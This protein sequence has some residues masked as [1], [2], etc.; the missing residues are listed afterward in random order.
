MVS[1]FCV[2]GTFLTDEEQKT[3]FHSWT[4]IIECRLG[5][6][7]RQRKSFECVLFWKMFNN[8]SQ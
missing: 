1:F 8:E 5:A 3:L 2:M 4:V 7:L 6:P